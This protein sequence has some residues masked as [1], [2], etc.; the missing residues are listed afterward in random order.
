MG[1]R[2]RVISKT[3]LLRE[4]ARKKVGAHLNVQWVAASVPELSEGIRSTRDAS[5]SLADSVIKETGKKQQWPSMICVIS[6]EQ[7]PQPK[8]KPGSRRAPPEPQPTRQAKDSEAVW[9]E[10]FQTEGDYSVFIPGRF[11]NVMRV[12]ATS[13]SPA[14]N[15][16][17]CSEA[18]PLIVLAD[19]DGKVVDDFKGRAKIKRSSIVN[20]MCKVVKD[21]GIVK[22]MQ[23]FSRLHELMR[24]LELTEVALL[25]ANEKMAELDGQL[26]ARETK[27]AERVRKVK[28]APETS[29]QTR[30]LRKRV[31]D[32][33]QNGLLPVQVRRYEIL[34]EEY[35]L[36][37]EV[38][39][40]E[41]KMP[42]KPVA[43]QGSAKS[44]LPASPP[45]D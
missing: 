32:F 33:Q 3:A 6:D 1:R 22:N 20:G 5:Q 17:F 36:L 14:K 21:D 31:E 8:P 23:P 9:I 45:G 42:P 29:Q 30:Q 24:S 10:L 26:K 4:E 40:P 2:V 27:D 7:K 15:K 19:K 25:K 39:L 16:Y 18:A 41:S 12:E 13:V 34:H 43:P 38:G 28:N 44:L 35:A 11:F 37:K